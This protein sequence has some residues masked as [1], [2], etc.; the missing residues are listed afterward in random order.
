[1][2]F[3]SANMS[4]HNHALLQD[5][6]CCD[7]TNNLT[8]LDTCRKVL[9]T[10]S[11][12]HE[13][14]DS[15]EVA[16]SPVRPQSPMWSCFLQSSSTSK[17]T[18]LPLDIGKLAC[19]SKAMKPSCQSLCWRAFQADWE[20]ALAQFEADCLSSSF[21]GELRRCLE[22][23]E[24]SCEMGCGGLSYCASYNDKSTTLFR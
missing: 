9:A 6:H 14:L 24:N 8:C 7:K 5:L 17:P 11:D 21:E 20:L 23:S 4:N 15:L 16:C 10:S 3:E 12:I 1:M 2:S 18:R 13:I 19:C 22:D